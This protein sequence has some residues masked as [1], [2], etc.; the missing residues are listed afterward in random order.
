M[1]SLL[2]C[3]FDEIR[4]VR[5]V[6]EDAFN[7]PDRANKL[8]LWGILQAYRF[9]LDFVKENFTGN[10]KFHPQMVMFILETMV[11]HVE[12]EGVSM[13]CE[14]V[15]TLPVIFQKLASSVDNFDSRF[16]DLEDTSGLEVGRGV[17]L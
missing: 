15:S 16:R 2:V 5:V 11:S 3:L 6:A 7:H 14:N 10:P 12:L 1:K 13:A 8:Y 9:M 17:A 4:A